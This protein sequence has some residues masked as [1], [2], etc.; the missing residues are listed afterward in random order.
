MVK[1]KE[2]QDW[3]NGLT[4]EEVQIRIEQNLVNEDTSVPTKKISRIIR[5]N[6]VTL[7]NILNVC[8]ALAI[9]AVGSYKNM[10]FMVIIISNTAISTI[11]EIHS[12]KMV[13]KLAVLA[14]RKAKVIRNGKKEE[15]SIYEI[16]KDDIV[17]FASGDQVATD[18]I[19][20]EGTV[21]VDESF[22]T[23]ESDTIFKKEGDNIVSGSIVVSGKCIAK[24]EHVGN[25]N[26]TS[27]ISTGAKYVKKIK[28]EM[29]KSLSQIIRIL[30]FVII[31]VG[32]LL[33]CNQYFNVKAGITES[34]VKTVAA[35]IGMIPEGL[36]LLTS[37][38]L[39]VSV[40]RMSKQKVLVQELY[41]IETLAR[42][43]TLCL[44][45]TGTLTEGKM[46]VEKQTALKDNFENIIANIAS[47]SEDNN[48]TIMAIKDKYSNI[49]EKFEVKEFYPFSSETKFSAVEFTNKKTYIIGA[50]EIILKDRIKE[51]EKQLSDAIEFRIIAVIETNEKIN[52]KELPNKFEVLGFIYIKDKIRKEAKD[53]LNYFKEQGVDIK[54]ISGDNPVTVSQIAKRVGMENY[55]NYIDLST[56]DT[57]EELKE[58]ATKYS[59][60]GRVTPMQKKEL[61]S[62]LRAQGRTVAMT[63][64]GVN[65]VMALKE[66][67][68][69]IAMANGSDATKNVSQLILL[70]SN[71][72][73]MP[74]IVLEGRRSINNLER[75]AS[76][77]LSKTIY[78]SILAFIF[79]VIGKEYPFMPIQLSAISTV[80]IGIPSFLLA[81][82]PNKD[83]IQ[84]KFLK[85]IVKKA[86]PTALTV[87]LSILT[88]AIGYKY[89]KVREEIYSSLCVIAA[90]F[91][92]ILLLFKMSKS[93]KSENNKLPVSIYR[94]SIAVV[95]TL[96]FLTELLAFNWLFA[97]APFDI[98]QTEIIFVCAV[99]TIDF[100]IL[101][102]V[103]DKWWK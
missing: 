45:K 85:N 52:K 80:T 102:Y 5:E 26:Y 33:F 31:P 54:I 6:F 66:A 22:I 51:F 37:T 38:V 56:I 75:S 25:D 82:E 86:L 95:M 83:R 97:I 12:K 67:D 76:L 71:F 84:G 30:T 39:A 35:M 73:S 4:D 68:C 42:V 41:C 50:P 103:I 63:G 17:E 61:I 70:D 18:S 40:V 53:T 98:M 14:S 36:V 94:F 93:R 7:F 48:P 58:A 15:I 1:E 92:A 99:C 3:K 72:A 77:F 8:L 34:V 44:D 90:G 16:V 60:F 64:D 9:F 19:I 20:K 81:L 21:E 78:S 11:Q 24:V 79:L 62:E 2:K 91:S 59:I 100:L 10:L 43:D 29:M 57:Q 47:A 49:K 88:I 27:Q 28:S 23:G 69:S 13:D 89:G 87:I 46:E 101:N 96:L 55:D 74:K 32:I 65:D